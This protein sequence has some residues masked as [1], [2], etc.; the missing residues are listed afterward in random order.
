VISHSSYRQPRHIITTNSWTIAGMVVV[1]ILLGFLIAILPLPVVAGLL[2]VIFLL[3]LLLIQPLGGIALVLLIGPL[4]A[5]ESLSIGPSYPKSGQILFIIT[6]C[7]W[8]AYGVIRRRINIPRTTLNLPLILFIAAA[9]FSLVDS[10]SLWAGFKEVVKWLGLG[11]AMLLVTDLTLNWQP[12]DSKR[13]LWR[14]VNAG[15]DIRWLVA[16]ILLAGVSQ[17][18]IGIW[19]FGLTG[20]GPDH[21]MILDGYFRAFGTFQQPNP[22]GGYMGVSAALAIGASI[23][24]LFAIIGDRRAKKRVTGTSWFWFLFVMGCAVI[25][26]LALLMS[27]SRGA[28]IGFAAAMIALIFF[29]PKKRWQGFI[30]TLAGLT[31]FLVMLQNNLLPASITTRLVSFSTEFLIGDVRGVHITEENFAVIERLAHWQAGV[32]MARDHLFSGVGFGNYEVVYGQYGLLNWPHP[33]GHAHNYYLNILAETGV[34]GILTYLLFWTVVIVQLVR[35]LGRLEWPNRGLV[36]GL[37]AAWIALS[38][39]HL[40]DKLYVNN[41]YLFFGVMLGLQQVL[42]KNDD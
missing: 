38:V 12:L 21:F 31:I 42:S 7:A 17:A 34:L 1:A 8:L 22:F 29:L 3:L 13:W 32:D 4:G 28:W 41:L 35:M 26:S 18:L 11:V 15:I 39:H 36:L 16:L 9:S 10:E 37:L 24:A 27:W 19:Q 5:L 20:N 14:R 25:L 6:V 33:L 2:L 23:G 40:F 30:L